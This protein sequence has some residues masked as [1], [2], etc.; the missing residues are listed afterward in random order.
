MRSGGVWHRPALLTSSECLLSL[1]SLVG[2]PSRAVGAEARSR[3]LQAEVRVL[4][5]ENEKLANEVRRRGEESAKLAS[6]L[7][8]QEEERKRL[9][10]I[11]TVHRTQME[12]NKRL[13]EEMKS[14]AD[15]L[16]NQLQ[17]GA[18]FFAIPKHFRR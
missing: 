8:D 17:V 16:E 12:K 7:K 10:R 1:Q 5:E 3:V 15:S 9:E 18:D 13:A 6:R 2:V 4:R 11:S 14:K